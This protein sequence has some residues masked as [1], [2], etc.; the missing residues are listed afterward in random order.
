MVTTETASA[1]KKPTTPFMS[2]NEAIGYLRVSVQKGYGKEL[3]WNAFA[4]KTVPYRT[5][6]QLL[7]PL[8]SDTL[9]SSQRERSYERAAGLFIKHWKAYRGSAAAELVTALKQ[10]P[11]HDI[12][13]PTTSLTHGSVVDRVD[14]YRQ[15][16]SIPLTNQQFL[17]LVNKRIAKAR[18]HP[19]EHLDLGPVA[20]LLPGSL[21]ENYLSKMRSS[22]SHPA[23]SKYFIFL[24]AL[25][26]LSGTPLETLIKLPRVV[27][28]RAT[29]FAV[30]VCVYLNDPSRAADLN[31]WSKEFEPL[32]E[33]LHQQYIG[34]PAE[35]QRNATP[36]REE[37]LGTLS[38]DL[39]REIGTY[40][41]RPRL[42]LEPTAPLTLTP[43]SLNLS[44]LEFDLILDHVDGVRTPTS[45][46]YYLGLL[47]A[48]EFARQLNIEWAA[49]GGNVAAIRQGRRPSSSAV[50]I[51]VGRSRDLNRRDADRVTHTKDHETAFEEASAALTSVAF[52]DTAYAHAKA[53][54]LRILWRTS[55]RTNRQRWYGVNGLISHTYFGRID[56]LSSAIRQLEPKQNAHALIY[57]KL[58]HVYPKSTALGVEVATAL[59]HEGRTAESIEMARLVL[60]A[61]GETALAWQIKAIGYGVLARNHKRADGAQLKVADWQ[62]V[63]QYYHRALMAAERAID[64]DRTQEDAFTVIGCLKLQRA[65]DGLFWW[66][67]KRI[68]ELCDRKDSPEL[69][70]SF[71][72]SV[73]PAL[74]PTERLTDEGAVRH[75]LNAAISADLRSA[76][77][78]FDAG[79]D[80]SPSR[81]RSVFWRLA[82]DGLL[83][84]EVDA[85]TPEHL[86]ET[87]RRTFV[88][89]GWIGPD[90][91]RA[92]LIARLEDAVERYHDSML[93]KL[94]GPDV[95]LAYAVFPWD[96]V[97]P[98]PDT[99]RLANNYIRRSRELL[100]RLTNAT[101]PPTHICRCWAY[102]QPV[103]EFATGLARAE[104]IIETH[105]EQFEC[106]K[107]PYVG[108][109][110]DTN[111]YEFIHPS[112]M[113][114]FSRA[115]FD[116][117]SPDALTPER[118]DV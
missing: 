34:T 46:D 116:G 35:E 115:P 86:Q 44:Y 97:G 22:E 19:D 43:L 32:C 91:T 10:L 18:V 17:A 6:A 90:A 31:S 56:P 14:Y 61:E 77:Q 25:A 60:A 80:C 55:A 76:R 117:S 81:G 59:L 50:T 1:E 88:E 3:P 113:G 75:H 66:R 111:R 74:P 100:N 15:H 36:A 99:W 96:F 29:S 11:V 33:R 23:D 39:Q 106:W 27:T 41:A 70:R 118:P 83:L 73:I 62:Q 72:A 5:W 104:R 68:T 87:S 95:M 9:S 57:S 105:R 89:V 109:A 93:L 108:Q 21:P 85:L 2:L 42:M 112:Y 53:V 30:R 65:M 94:F 7:D 20:W 48:V 71:F 67:G 4:R 47:W 98:G 37:L 51:D 101:H 110:I 8:T 40:P 49:N 82:V 63:M 64:A 114:G 52:S 92:A 13:K 58:F 84:A 78:Y 102:M 107:G 69:M 16:Q 54:D 26:E 45:V 79:L 38:P 28:D 24:R 103:E 12:E